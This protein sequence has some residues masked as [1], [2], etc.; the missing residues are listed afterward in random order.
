[1]YL[2]A[3]MSFKAANI[4]TGQYLKSMISGKWVITLLLLFNLMEARISKAFFGGLFSYQKAAKSQSCYFY[5]C[6]KF[7]CMD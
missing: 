2:F 3:C 6:K 5:N 4:Q 1:M 7:D